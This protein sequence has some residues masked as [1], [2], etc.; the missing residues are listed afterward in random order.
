MVHD[1]PR[2]PKRSSANLFKNRSLS[3]SPGQSCCF[4]ARDAASL[5][6]GIEGSLEPVRYI[7]A[8]GEARFRHRRRSRLAARPG[9]ADEKHLR[10][11][12]DAGLFEQA[13]EFFDKVRI[14][15]VV[16]ETL[17]FGSDYPLAR[18]LEVRK[19]DK[20]PFRTRPHINQSRTGVGF[21]TL[22]CRID[23]NVLDFDAISQL[24]TPNFPHRRPRPK[25]SPS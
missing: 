23:G 18:S 3:L 10:V 6:A 21:Q 4:P 16:W 9:A 24:L 2:S 17:P 25:P 5:A 15:P 22:P 12:R 7:A 20:R 19:S 13:G 8:A 14:D 11:L 1:L